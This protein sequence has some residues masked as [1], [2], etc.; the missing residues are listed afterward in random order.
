VASGPQNLPL[1]GG[2]FLK[3]VTFIKTYPTA[4]LESCA[5]LVGSG[6]GDSTWCRLVRTA[7]SAWSSR[8]LGARVAAT[9]SPRMTSTWWCKN[10]FCMPCN[11]HDLRTGLAVILLR[12]PV[13]WYT[14]W[15]QQKYDKVTSPRS[16]R[17]VSSPWD[18]QPP[19]P[20]FAPAPHRCRQAATGEACRAWGFQAVPGR[21]VTP[22]LS[23][24]MSRCIHIRYWYRILSRRGA[25]NL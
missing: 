2:R 24:V 10:T 14:K 21:R 12:P 7:A 20:S 3:S 11:Q 17:R 18:S 13:Y 5:S 22:A 1:V 25:A 16:A 9:H 15:E 6:R 8:L 4:S 19:L 23:L